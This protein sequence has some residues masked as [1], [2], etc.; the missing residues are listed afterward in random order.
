MDEL[1]L[2]QARFIQETIEMMKLRMTKRLGAAM[3][4]AGCHSEFTLAQMH[5]LMVVNHHEGLSVK[6]LAQMLG[7]S[8]PSASAMVERLVELGA[9]LREQ[10]KQDRRE[11]AIFVSAEGRA[12]LEVVERTML[13]GILHVME[14]LGRD[15]TAMW[16]QVYERIR[17]IMQEEAAE[18]AQENAR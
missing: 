18:Q 2:H 8:P 9:V 11:V 7:V 6:E 10:S 14:R 13:E 15:Y 12:T 16:C 5:A 1:A 17:A 4:A 3:E